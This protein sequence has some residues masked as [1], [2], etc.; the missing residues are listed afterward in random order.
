M[1]FKTTQ[2]LV[3]RLIHIYSQ[4]IVDITGTLLTLTERL[5]GWLR[6]YPQD[7]IESLYRSAAVDHLCDEEAVG[8]PESIDTRRIE[9]DKMLQ[10]STSYSYVMLYHKL[11]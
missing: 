2:V 5:A 11:R 10:E 8:D 4:S 1:K 7:S 9:G 6:Q 3:R